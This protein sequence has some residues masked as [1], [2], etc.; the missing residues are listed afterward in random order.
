MARLLRRSLPTPRPA[1]LV[2]GCN[3]IGDYPGTIAAAAWT[4]T[5]VR[6]IRRRAAASHKTLAGTPEDVLQLLCAAP[7]ADSCPLTATAS[8]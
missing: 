2:T 8:G 3:D 6:W 4:M 5:A 7:I 1:V